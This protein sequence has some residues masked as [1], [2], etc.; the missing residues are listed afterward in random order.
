MPETCPVFRLRVEMCVKMCDVTA[1]AAFIRHRMGELGLT[2]SQSVADQT[3][4][5]DK[6]I[7]SKGVGLNPDSVRRIL[8]GERRT[9]HERTL[10]L[11][12]LALETDINTLRAYAE[13]RTRDQVHEYRVPPEAHGALITNRL[14]H[15]WS[16]N[17]RAASEGLRTAWQAGYE[18]CA[19]DHGLDADPVAVAEAM[20]GTA[21]DPDSLTAR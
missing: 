8:L 15:A 2:T 14:Q 1:L 13:D 3:K 20:S 4:R 17:I 9:I 21:P 19:R 7:T 10:H 16:E 6:G 18:Q 11:L 12:A 5:W